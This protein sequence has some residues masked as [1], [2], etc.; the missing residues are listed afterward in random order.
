MSRK[1]FRNT[2]KM[3]DSM[4]PKDAPHHAVIMS[5]KIYGWWLFNRPSGALKL[6]VDGEK[7]IKCENC[8]DELWKDEDG[9]WVHISTN[10]YRC[11]IEGSFFAEP[12]EEKI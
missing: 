2:V 11:N 6:K 5:D 3:C 7:M 4:F 8:D 12:Q 1:I 10:R 9:T